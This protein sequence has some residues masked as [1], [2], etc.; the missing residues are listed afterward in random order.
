MKKSIKCAVLSLL[1]VCVFVFSLPLTT[2]AADVY[3]FTINEPAKGTNQG[4]INLLVEDTSG[5]R[6][7]IC[8]SWTLLP[9]FTD[10]EVTHTDSEMIITIDSDKSVSFIGRSNGNFQLSAGFGRS[11]SGDN[12]RNMFWSVYDNSV[13]MQYTYSLGSNKVIGYQCYGNAVLESDDLGYNNNVSFSVSWGDDSQVTSLMTEML[14]QLYVAAD[15]DLTIIS[16]LNELLGHAQTAESILL[17]I[18]DKLSYIYNM[19]VI[20]N[21]HLVTIQNAVLQI[22]DYLKAS[23]ESTFEE[24]STDSI[25]DYNK[26]EEELVSGADDTSDIEQQIGDVE[27]NAEASSV[28]WGII[29]SFYNQHP[30]VFG[31]VIAVL[32]VGIIALILNR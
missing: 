24:P 1:M 6:S 13:A 20:I 18:Q 4:Y 8:I 2:F 9:I 19:Q 5:Y 15:N 23:G 16:Q 29:Q 28:I 31:L 27:I 25:N 26:A 3:N 30:K 7:V 17:A 12:K 22:R 11:L 21:N 10:N 32:A 14:A